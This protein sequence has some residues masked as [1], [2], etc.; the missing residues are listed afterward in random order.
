MINSIRLQ[1]FRSYSDE[2]FE[3][4]EGVNIIVG[5]NASGK[6]NLLEAVMALSRGSSYRARDSE[7]IK[8][9]ANW[10][11]LDGY[12][13]SSLRSLKLELAGEKVI[14][15]FLIN[16][17]PYHRLSLERAVPVVLFEPNH[18]QIITRGPDSRRDYIDDLLERSLPS[19]K[20]T[21]ASYRRTLA[22][23]NALLKHGAV[24]AS[25]QLFAWNI[26]LSELG[27]QIAVARHGIVEDI[28]KSLGRVYSKIAGK[29]SKVELSYQAQFP[30][31]RYA[32]RLLSKLE[33]TDDKDFRLG[34]TAYGPHREDIT[35][36]LNN[37][38]ANQTASRGETRSL[39]LALKIYELKM[40]GKI[41]NQKP[42]L[43]LDDVFSELDGARRRALV[44]QLKKHQTLITTTDA[45]AALEYF[46]GAHNLISL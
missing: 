5:P 43:L 25:Q 36:Y 18:L 35:F 17:K 31:D 22:Q 29:R 7:L 3:F 19:F 27:A 13:G 14:K 15:T 4:D 10:A 30:V 32:S 12:F 8:F 44:D 38:S 21:A 16:D 40:L 24:R 46:A 41:Y 26:R 23:R 20:T 9:G 28:N 33:K 42:V 45:E 11:R 6:T 39:M 1:R 2:S 34:F 37:Q